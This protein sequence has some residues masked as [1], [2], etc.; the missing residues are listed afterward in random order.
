[1]DENRNGQFP[2]LEDAFRQCLIE[3]ASHEVSDD[4]FPLRLGDGFEE[5]PIGAD[6]MFK[7]TRSWELY[8]RATE[9]RVQFGPVHD[10]RQQLNL[11]L[12]KTY[13]LC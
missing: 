2:E 6:I 4:K 13:S 5:R 3:V 8:Q 9:N 7:L 10:I 1:M 12:E 11:I